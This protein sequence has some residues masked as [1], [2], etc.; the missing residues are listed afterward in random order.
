MRP[1]LD[2]ASGNL[3]YFGYI[4]VKYG[5]KWGFNG[6][7]L[8]DNVT[9]FIITLDNACTIKSRRLK[10]IYLV[11]ALIK[12]VLS[13]GCAQVIL[14]DNILY[15]KYYYVLDLIGVSVDKAVDQIPKPVPSV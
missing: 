12:G 15:S 5:I 6:Y 10:A 3:T 4:V 11:Y 7:R 8:S 9:N 13:V 2:Y 1:H 14:S